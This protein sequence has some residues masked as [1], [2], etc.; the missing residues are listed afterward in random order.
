MAVTQISDIIDPE[1]LGHQA[2]ARFPDMLTFAQTGLVRINT[3]F[4]LGSPGTK[5]KMPFWK[6][7]GSFANLAEG[8]SITLGKIQAGAE[9]ATVQRAALG[10]AVYDTAALVSS[11]D[12]MTEIVDQ[13]SRRAAEY[14]E[15]QA[16]IEFEKTPNTYDASGIG[17]GLMDQ[18]TI[19]KAMISTLGDNH[20]KLMAGG[21]LIMHSKVYGDLLMAGAIQNNYQSGLDV[22]KTG[23][24]S[25]LMGMPIFV[26]DRV[27]V[28]TVSGVPFYKSYLIGPDTLALFYQRA[29]RVEFDRDT[30][31]QQDI[32]VA[33]IHFS[34]HLFGYDDLAGAVAAEQNKSIVAVTIR[35]K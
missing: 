11:S 2:S 1:V 31:T 29:L 5:F 20:G 23:T 9:Y 26:S 34:V 30:L 33:T 3:E 27:T 8:G 17:G 6:K 7:I 4:P 10:D 18:N 19:A 35:T 21:A 13:V 12:P 32:V 22:I 28:T 24:V 15:D 14:I 16:I 25:F